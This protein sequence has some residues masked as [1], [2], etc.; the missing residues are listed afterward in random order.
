MT[1]VAV[2]DRHSREVAE[3]VNQYSKLRAAIEDSN[4]AMKSKGTE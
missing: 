1:N 3:F 4:D 2:R